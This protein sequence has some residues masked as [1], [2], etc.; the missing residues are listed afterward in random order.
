MPLLRP[1]LP[2]S[3]VAVPR[4]HLVLV[5]LLVALLLVPLVQSPADASNAQVRSDQERQ[6][7]D[8]VNSERTSRGLAPL[9][10]STNAR[11][12]AR[13]WSQ[14]M[15]SGVGLKHRSPLSE[16]FTGRWTR[17]GENV[18]YGGTVTR[19]H[20]A[21]MDSTGHRANVLNS[22]FT[23]VGVGSV[24]S[25]RGVIWV[26]FNFGTGSDKVASRFTSST[27]STGFRDVPDNHTF[28]DNIQWLAKT[29]ITRGCDANQTRFCP[30]APV[31]RGQMAAFLQRA[32]D[33][34]AGTATFR[35]VGRNHTFNAAI[36]ALADAGITRGCDANQTRFCPDAPVTRGQMAA[37]L[38][39]ALDLPA[40]TAT[41]RDVGRNHTFNAA[42]AA[43]ADAGITRGCD[44]NQTRFC[45]DAPVTRGQM[46]AFLQRAL[47]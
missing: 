35:D 14:Q 26:T 37:F 29:G 16:P 13:D 23:W 5:G 12:V 17:L 44:A 6:F 2:P 10:L 45:P 4:R 40:G 30:D 25:D 7:L 41:F 3:A 11:G 24:V 1:A 18:G 27:T 9:K 38:Q 39:R 31:T 47:R 32:L 34:P 33:L 19:L 22:S 8:L 36:A 20:Q 28:A 43:L 46:A 15:A 42:I 21:F